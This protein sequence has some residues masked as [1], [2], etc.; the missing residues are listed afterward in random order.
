MGSDTWL[1]S[2][3]S[4]DQGQIA[5][6]EW[7]TSVFEVTMTLRRING[8][9]AVQTKAW[10]V[11]QARVAS[12]F[13]LAFPSGCP[14]PLAHRY[15]CLARSLLPTMARVPKDQRGFGSYVAARA[16]AADPLPI[17]AA[18]YSVR[19]PMMSLFASSRSAFARS[20]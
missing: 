20:S 3:G 7:S 14:S 17:P 2:P 11:P 19:A 1:L 15:H 10:L 12:Q 16:N 4:E 8:A 5:L 9:V 6:P 18:G 13:H